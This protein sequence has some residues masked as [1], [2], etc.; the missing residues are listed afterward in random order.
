MGVPGRE[1]LINF[2]K[3]WHFYL[4]L[5]CCKPSHQKLLPVSYFNASISCYLCCCL[6]KVVLVPY[7]LSFLSVYS[8]LS[9]SMHSCFSLTLLGIRI[10]SKL[11]SFLDGF[12]QAFSLE[13]S[14]LLTLG[15]LACLLPYRLPLH[16]PCFLLLHSVYRRPAWHLFPWIC[17]PPLE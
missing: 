14:L 9:F 8:R 11:P 13:G 17:L 2:W 15:I 7:F 5:V 1:I 3:P 16:S 12:A 6:P 10:T 4:V